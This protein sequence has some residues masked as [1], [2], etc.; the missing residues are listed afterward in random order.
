MHVPD[1]RVVFAADVVFI[2]STPVMWAGPLEGWLRALDTI[3]ALEPDVVVPGHGPVTDVAGLEQV[4][5]YWTLPG[6]GLAAAAGRARDR[7]L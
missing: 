6:V 7:A 2:G 1:A 5:A 3:A 4:R